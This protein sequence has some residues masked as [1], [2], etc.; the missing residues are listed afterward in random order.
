ML[1]M[2]IVSAFIA[3]FVIA[4]LFFA[5][6]QR[7]KLKKIICEF[8]GLPNSNEQLLHLVDHS[9]RKVNGW[10]NIT[11]CYTMFH[12]VFNVISISFSCISIYCSFFE[13]G[14]NFDTIASFISLIAISLNLFLRCDR[15]WTIYHDVLAKARIITF[16]FIACVR[17]TSDLNATTKKYNEKIIKLE[18]GLKVSDIS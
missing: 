9:I 11:T 17:T 14:Q 15:K 10:S 3:V 7:F 2:I 12:Y 13:K 6:K 4:Y 1:F 16:N 18:K 5:A 8:K